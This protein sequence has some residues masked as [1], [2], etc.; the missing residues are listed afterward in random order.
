MNCN[1]GSVLRI[2]SVTGTHRLVG[3]KQERKEG[4]AKKGRGDTSAVWRDGS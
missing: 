4:K 2:K 3:L 1:C